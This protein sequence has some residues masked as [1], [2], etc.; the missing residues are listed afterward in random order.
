MQCNN[1]NVSN[2]A[3]GINPDL[4][5][6]REIQKKKFKFKSCDDGTLLYIHHTICN[7]GNTLRIRFIH[8][9]FSHNNEKLIAIDH[10]GHIFVFNLASEC[11]W[12]LTEHIEGITA[13]ECIPETSHLVLG[14]KNGLMCIIDYDSGNELVRLK[15]HQTR[16]TTIKFPPWYAKSHREQ[17]SN[18][19]ILFQKSESVE[20][21]N[22]NDQPRAKPTRS[23]LF[24]VLTVDCAKLYDR[25]NFVEVHR[26]SY[27]LSD[28]MKRI[29]LFQWVPKA[30]MLMTCGVDG[31]IRVWTCDFK[32]VKE[33]NMKKLK[34]NYL[35]QFRTDPI[36]WQP[37][38]GILC[39]GGN[40]H[41]EIERLIQHMIIDERSK[42]YI[43]SAQFLPS[44]KFLI[45]NCLDNSLII[46]ACDAWQ[47][48]KILALTN[49]HLA[50]FEIVHI[51]QPPFHFRD[52]FTILAKTVEGDLLLMNLE[53]GHKTYIEPRMES[54]CY[55]FR[56]SCNGKMLA[57]VLKSGEILL[58][59]LEFHSRALEAN[60]LHQH[61][62]PANEPTGKIHP[63]PSHATTC[64]PTAAQRR[65]SGDL[66]TNSNL[67]TSLPSSSYSTPT[68]VASFTSTNSVPSASVFRNESKLKLD[69]RLE[70]IHDKISKTL[71]KNRLR[72]ILKEF[73]EYPEKHRA[74]IWRALLELPQNSDCFNTLLMKGNHACVSDYDVKFSNF[75][76]RIVRNVKK[77]V[78]CLAHWSSVFAHCDF[79][80]FFVFPFVRIYHNDSLTCFETVATV[81]LNHCQLWFEFVPLE[82][83]NYLGMIE[84]ILCEYEPK[85]MI[86][87]RE[88]N[89]SSRIYAM[90]MMETAFAENFNTNQWSRLWDHVISNE[91][92]FMV[93]FIVAYN[94][95]HRATIM[96]CTTEDDI[97]AFFHEPSVA[98]ISRV[99][100]RAYDMMEK[101]TDNNHPRYYMKSF[102]SLGGITDSEKGT[103]ES[104]RQKSSR[105]SGGSTCNSTYSKFSNFPKQLVEIRADELNCLKTEQNRLEAK[106]LKMEKLE[107]T[108]HN[109]MMDSLV[110]EE[111]AKRMK[112][113]ERKFEEALA[114]EVRRI[115]MQRKL[116]L[117]HKKQLR[118]RENEVLLESRNVQLRHNAAARESELDRL[119]KTLQRE[120]LRDE[121]DM[122]FAEEDIKLKEM[123]LQAHQ[124]ETNLKLVDDNS[125]EQRYHQSIQQLERQ[126][127]KL[128]QDIERV[129]CYNRSGLLYENCSSINNR[130]APTEGIKTAK[131]TEI[132]EYSERMKDIYAQLEALIDAQQNE[133]NH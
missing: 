19:K 29:D 74:T 82:P 68:K 10:R 32:L 27:G 33:L 111:H 35:R 92:Y 133:I 97:R 52:E 124:Q 11:Y 101:C 13:A 81:L 110:Q 104:Y 102:R 51:D 89:V 49:F 77:C 21:D 90:T 117:L 2:V 59:N 76:A 115:D 119:L 1:M 37:E 105:S 60:K 85:L 45:L 107:S 127:R 69:K 75:E 38:E 55:K 86:F 47:I 22:R 61:L 63:R 31:I 79:L 121:T 17:Y 14:N 42:G 25:R 65:P 125:L 15:A 129:S 12:V 99:L 98:D 8:V 53:K 94:A 54:K 3:S 109:R 112:E 106:I 26:L 48:C 83:F 5:E 132:E 7:D 41:N 62:G 113:V 9:C 28:A 128:Q 57:N 67:A 126:K 93:F 44:G 116:L 6:N 36:R 100:K 71:D 30:S 58:H 34:E 70:E 4:V 91:P 108:L 123:E 43:K 131:G 120:R 78:S 84:N 66:V 24:L 87:Y 50:H 95:G 122:M 23:S 20:P 40:S 130:M 103:N 73:G 114:T 96:K 72:P 39:E 88:R 80:P 118:E 16:I 56:L 46:I 18:R 64:V